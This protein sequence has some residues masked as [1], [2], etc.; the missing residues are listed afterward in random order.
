MKI[1]YQTFR[2]QAACRRMLTD[3]S[4]ATRELLEV[5]CRRCRTRIARDAKEAR[6]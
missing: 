5:T 3:K 1:H 4:R 6:Q 2:H